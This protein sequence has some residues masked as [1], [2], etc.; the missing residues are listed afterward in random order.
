MSLVAQ[1]YES[2]ANAGLLKEFLGLVNEVP[3]TLIGKPQ[4]PANTYRDF[5]NYIRANAGKLNIAHAGLGSASH[6][7]GLMWQSAI[8]KVFGDKASRDLKEVQPIAE[9]V[10]SEYPKLESL[11]N[12]E[13]REKTTDFK[14]RI[15]AKIADEQAQIDQLRNEIEEDAKMPIGERE[16]R[17][18]EIDKL[19]EKTLGQIEEVLLELLPEA[20]AVMKETARRLGLAGPARR[21][22]EV[23][24][25]AAPPPDST[26]A[27]ESRDPRLVVPESGVL[28]ERCS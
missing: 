17:Y 6:L 21:G 4:L 20:F 25:L 14:S 19:E 7:C 23:R 28:R 24:V 3:M 12:D 10:K 16:R 15:A 26:V 2:A 11:S 27:P 5:E 1:I 22:R 8:K 13:L 18:E 9:K